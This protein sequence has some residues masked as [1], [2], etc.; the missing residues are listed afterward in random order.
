MAQSS[1]ARWIVANKIG[2]NEDKFPRDVPTI[3]EQKFG[4]FLITAANPIDDRNSSTSI[5]SNSVSRQ[6]EFSTAGGNIFI[7]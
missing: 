3:Y 4:Q 1:P 6:S 2:K 5:P 7:Y